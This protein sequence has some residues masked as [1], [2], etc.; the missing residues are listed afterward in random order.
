MFTLLSGQS[1]LTLL[2]ISTFTMMGKIKV[3]LWDKDCVRNIAPITLFFTTDI[4][5]GMAAL[6]LVN[7]PMFTALRRLTILCVLSLEYLVLGI[8]AK[9]AIIRAVAVA[10]TG[11]F[12]AGMGDLTFDMLGYIMAL[13]ADT[14]TASYRVLAKKLQ[15]KNFDS[16][17]LMY[18]NSLMAVPFTLF[19]SWYMGEMDALRTFEYLDDPGFRASFMISCVLAFLLNYSMFCCTMVNSPLTT[20]I[21]G[22]SKNLVVAF[23]GL[24]AFGDVIINPINIL[25]HCICS[26]GAIMYFRAT[27][28]SKQK[29]KTDTDDREMQSLSQSSSKDVENGKT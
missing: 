11:A 1:L 14:T 28:A 5:L 8:V 19:G 25:G 16:F 20:S 23:V 21:T 26:A 18:Y 24:F 12:I 4:L 22:Q 7:I 17:T 10:V 3:P 13:L 15:L 9:P 27:L 2:L 29:S 6:R